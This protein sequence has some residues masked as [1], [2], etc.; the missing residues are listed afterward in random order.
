MSKQ[1]QY[2]TMFPEGSEQFIEEEHMKAYERPT[3]KEQM[4]R[5]GFPF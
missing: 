5:L 2:T 4:D 3:E 1:E